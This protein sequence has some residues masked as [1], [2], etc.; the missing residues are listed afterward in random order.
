M[1]KEIIVSWQ[2]LISRSFLLRVAGKVIPFRTFRHW[3][4]KPFGLDGNFL[5]GEAAALACGPSRTVH[6]RHEKINLWISRFWPIQTLTRGLA[7]A[8]LRAAAAP[9]GQSHKTAA[10]GIEQTRSEPGGSVG[11]R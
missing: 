3:Q 7:L 11:E 6:P 2:S 10:R 9:N 8:L 5:R 1:M 4:A